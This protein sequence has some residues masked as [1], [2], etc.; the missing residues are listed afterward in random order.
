MKKET[1]N[2]V[3]W[4]L[5]LFAYWCIGCFE[6]QVY[7]K[8]YIYFAAFA[9]SIGILYIAK[10]EWLAL[11]GLAIVSLITAV[12]RYEY[13]FVVLPVV[14]LCYAHRSAVQ[15]IN[16]KKEKNKHTEN[17]TDTY[18]TISFI[19][20]IGQIIYSVIA[21]QNVSAHNVQNILYILRTA[22]IFIMLF[23][24]LLVQAYSKKERKGFAV[25]SKSKNSFKMIYT[26]GLFG[27]VIMIS[28]FYAVNEYGTQAGKTE[29]LLWFALA[30]LMAIN[31]D[32]FMYSGIDKV[33]KRL[34]DL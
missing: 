28:T 23:V 6:M 29:Y 14:L 17:L 9:V 19:L 2:T 26:V 33:E 18:T 12:F 27:S 5:F 1:R 24:F 30:I 3:L 34:N 22:P 13:L 21:Y 8:T 15:T 11:I 7:T 25:D 4:C 16:A 32:P 10:K 20:M 31:K